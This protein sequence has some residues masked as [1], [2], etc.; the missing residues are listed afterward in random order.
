[1][2]K[3][4]HV[5]RTGALCA[6]LHSCSC[7]YPAVARRAGTTLDRSFAFGARMPQSVKITLWLAPRR[8][9]VRLTG[10]QALDTLPV[11]E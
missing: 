1:L 10:W 8:I 6:C 9:I 11:S 7:E 2:S 3:R 4:A 5:I